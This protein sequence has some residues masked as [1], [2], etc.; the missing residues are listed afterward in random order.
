M[1]KTVQAPCQ[2]CNAD[3][4]PA[5]QD[6]ITDS[7]PDPIS[8]GERTTFTPADSSALIFASAVPWLPLI[9]APAWPM[10][11]PDGAVTPAM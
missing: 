1:D 7:M 3:R 10:R 4:H 11:L 9:M 5:L 8:A 6:F 2:N